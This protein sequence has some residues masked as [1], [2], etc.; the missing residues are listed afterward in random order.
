MVKD[1]SLRSCRRNAF[2]V[3]LYRVLIL[4]T[5]RCTRNISQAN[6]H[7]SR[8]RT[9][10]P[11]PSLLPRARS[12]MKLESTRITQPP[13]T[14]RRYSLH[15]NVTQQM[16]RCDLQYRPHIH[17]IRTQVHQMRIW[18]ATTCPPIPASTRRKRKRVAGDSRARRT[19]CR[20]LQVPEIR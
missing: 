19:I 12:Y 4:P 14:R 7:Q 13:I 2:Q 16:P 1:I 9:R 11:F 20:H 6:D 3:L 18:L 10:S 5:T 8:R 17:S 15:R